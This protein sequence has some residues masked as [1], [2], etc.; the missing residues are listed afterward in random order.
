MKVPKDIIKT[1]PWNIVPDAK[2]YHIIE[3]RSGKGN[4]K[5]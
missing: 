2:I 5:F 3:V 1:I 4:G